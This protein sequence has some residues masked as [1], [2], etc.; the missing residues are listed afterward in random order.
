MLENL[1]EATRVHKRTMSL[2]R[3]PGAVRL[4][5]E[6][7]SLEGVIVRASFVLLTATVCTGQSQGPRL[8]PR[9]NRWVRHGP[10]F[11]EAFLVRNP[12]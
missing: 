9:H 2:K 3:I 10:T 12:Y 8:A 4:C 11:Q 7:S 6:G 1:Y 5:L